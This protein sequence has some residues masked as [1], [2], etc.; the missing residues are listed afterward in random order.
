MK[1]IHKYWKRLLAVLL[2][3]MLTAGIIIYVYYRN[4]YE[5]I[6]GSAEGIALY[7]QTIGGAMSSDNVS[8]TVI[9]EDE[10]TKA[11][12]RYAISGINSLV[13]YHKEDKSGEEY[14]FELWNNMETYYIRTVLDGET[15][16]Y[17]VDVIDDTRDSLNNCF[18]NY[19]ITISSYLG[20]ANVNRVVSFDKVDE[21]TYNA[22]AK[23][24][25]G[26]YKL[27]F[28]ISDGLLSNIYMYE[29]E[30]MDSSINIQF[31]KF[32]INDQS[33]YEKYA[34]N[35]CGVDYVIEMFNYDMTE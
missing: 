30:D 9:A 23:I 35:H 2:I 12:L 21:N 34:T 18:Y 1:L 32:S 10:N 22:V 5:T 20:V 17:K 14:L 8:T 3:T 16:I 24:E 28:S 25:D 7:E 31:D 15:S 26:E 4:S 13:S 6:E 33:V 11:S 27:R 29:S 19:Y